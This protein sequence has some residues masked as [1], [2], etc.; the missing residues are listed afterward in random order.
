MTK[1]QAEVL[2]FVRRFI[3]KNGYSPSISEIAEGAAFSP[4]TVIS[5]LNQLSERGYLIR[6]RGWQNIQL[7]DEGCNARAA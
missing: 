5:A 1:T 2:K 3:G 7:P 4:R 6:G